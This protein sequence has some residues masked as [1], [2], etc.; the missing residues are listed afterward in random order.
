MFRVLKSTTWAY[1]PH[2]A[3]LLHDVT[4]VRMLGVS[5]SGEELPLPPKVDKVKKADD[6]RPAKKQ[7]ME[8]RSATTSSS[9]DDCASRP[10]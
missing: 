9:D 1:S 7:K 6:K 3:L 4:K 10:G 5:S 2:D 8:K